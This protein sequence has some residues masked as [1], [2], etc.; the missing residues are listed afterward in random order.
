M[1]WHKS[2]CTTHREEER[3][4][5]TKIECLVHTLHVFRNKKNVNHFKSRC[6]HV[7]VC[8]W[9]VNLSHRSRKSRKLFYIIDDRKERNCKW[10]THTHK[11]VFF[12]RC[13]HPFQPGALMY[14]CIDDYTLTCIFNRSI[15]AS[16]QPIEPSPLQMSIRNGSKCRNSRNP[17]SGPVTG[18]LKT[19]AGFSNCLKRRKNF[20]PWLSPDLELTNTRS[21]EKHVP[22]GLTTSQAS[23]TPTECRHVGGTTETRLG[24]SGHLTGILGRH[25]VWT[26][27]LHHRQRQSCRR[28]TEPH[29]FS[30]WLHF[31]ETGKFPSCHW[32]GI[33]KLPSGSSIIS[34]PLKILF[35]FYFLKLLL[36]MWFMGHLP[37][38]ANV[39]HLQFD[40]AFAAHLLCTLNLHTS[41]DKPCDV[42]PD[43]A[44]R[45]TFMCSE[46]I[47][48]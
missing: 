7:Y 8:G 47:N 37:T 27:A 45:H 17:N 42:T 29:V 30:Q 26:V 32:C 40:I 14:K 44:S 9:G 48:I 16:T 28:K 2:C 35:L 4:R 22:N 46:W 41:H 13:R 31:A 3:E 18:K 23:S 11:F 34:L 19:W 39:V 12:L 25:D 1:T 33:I 10:N 15:S 43:S 5:L 36:L 24:P 6:V 20:T 38:D 21:G